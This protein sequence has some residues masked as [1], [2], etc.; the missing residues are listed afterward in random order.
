VVT[1]NGSFNGTSNFSQSIVK[2]SPSL[3]MLDWVAPTN[4]ATLSSHDT[5]FNSSGAMLIPG[6]G[7]VVSGSKEGALYV[8]NTSNLGHLGGFLQRFSVSSSEVHTSV[9]YWDSASV[10][11][12]V[13]VW[14]TGGHLQAHRVS[15]SGITT[16]AQAS[17]PESLGSPRTVS[18]ISLSANGNT[19]GILWADALG[20]LRAYDATNVSHELYNSGQNSARDSCGSFSKNAPPTIA[21]GKVYF[22]SF[23]GHFCVYGLLAAQ[24]ANFSLSAAPSTQTITAGSSTSYTVTV[25]PSN[26]FSGAVTLSVAGLPSGA[27]GSFSPNPVSGGSG[28]STL[29]ISTAGSTPAGTYTL[30]I[31]GASSNPSLS[32]STTVTLVVSCAGCA[33]DFALSV[34]PGS[35]TV[36]AGSGTTYTASVTPS[37][38]FNS[39]VSLSVAGLPSGATASFSP[40]P[41]SGGS[42]S[43]ILNVSTMASTPVGT[44]TLTV[45]GTGAGISH[46]MTVSLTVTPP[47]QCV[48]ASATHGWVNTPFTSQTG[49]FTAT[50]DATPS[51]SNMNSV[52]AL[53]HGAG[54]AYTAFANLVAF[55]GTTGTILARNGGAYAG[56]TPA[57]PYSGGN[58]YHFRL[59]INIPAHTYS[60]FVTP[61][62][63]SE[64]TVGSNFAF[65]TEQNTVTSLNNYGV[66][67]G[68]TSGTLQVCNFTT[69]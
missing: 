66:F 15:P 32:H 61:P 43:S 22:A 16:T 67:V 12:L 65:R 54:T 19:D 56:P 14:G 20:T 51:L 63:G 21:N 52:V 17:G 31:N 6:T 45:T 9:I 29:A 5:D 7:L 68:A 47:A 59:A 69:Q 42:G 50:F 11:P 28:S 39:N 46:S 62:G 18:M 34:T 53:S 44:S 1:G 8:S 3:S 40:N 35:R 41:I 57:I 37:N 49:T 38:G 26:G 58:T 36:S 24:P 55:N 33:P 27:T 25:S 60:I 23:S 13:Y 4:N 64:L 48:T 2:L 30:T 10:G